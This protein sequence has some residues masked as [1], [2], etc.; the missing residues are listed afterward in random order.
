MF[1]T[2]FAPFR[3][4]HRAGLSSSDPGRWNQHEERARFLISR[5]DYA[6]A[7]AEINQAESIDDRY[8][9]LW[10][11]KGQTLQALNEF[12]KAKQAHRRARDEDVC[13]L[14]AIQPLVDVARSLP[15][16]TG[17]AVV[18]L[19]QLVEQH[20]EHGLTG[21]AMFHDHVHPTVEA[22]RLLALAI[23]DELQDR[24]I[25]Q[26]DATWGEQS[27]RRVEEKIQNSV[28]PRGGIGALSAIEIL[29]IRC[30]CQ[31]AAASQLFRNLRR[32][33]LNF[34]KAV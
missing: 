3:S 27:I 29:W 4:E 1:G 24:G 25:V 6:A 5:G 16:S 10:L 13:P 18:D 9:G 14:R 23:L 30:C 26:P 2:D 34:T 32:T 20:S 7:L 33:V 19:E 22:N 11:L 31:T 8:A 12:D 21:K 28:A 17:E 15:E